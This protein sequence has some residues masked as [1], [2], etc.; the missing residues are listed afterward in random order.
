MDSS[1]RNYTHLD[2]S[3][4]IR[5]DWASLLPGIVTGASGKWTYRRG[6]GDCENQ[7]H[8]DAA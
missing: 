4:Q 1:K 3:L 7:S 8:D 2:G 6:F 5:G